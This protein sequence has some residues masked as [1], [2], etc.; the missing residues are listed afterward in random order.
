MK[1]QRSRCT[2]QRGQFDKEGARRLPRMKTVEAPE[3]SAAQQARWIHDSNK[4]FMKR[5]EYLNNR[6]GIWWAKEC[7]FC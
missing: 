6:P 4:H 5:Q 3:P 7:P 2:M 1:P